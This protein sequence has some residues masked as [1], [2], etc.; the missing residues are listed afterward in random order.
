MFLAVPL[1]KN[2]ILGGEELLGPTKNFSAPPHSNNMNYTTIFPKM[3]WPIIE[4]K[5]K[6]F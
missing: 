6:K 4:N 3:S 5:A 2:L 1:P